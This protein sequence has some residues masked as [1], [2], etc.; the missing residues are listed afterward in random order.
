MLKRLAILVMLLAVANTFSPILGQTAGNDR[1]QGHSAQKG[2]GSSRQTAAEPV[3]APKPDTATGSKE[4]GNPSG[5]QGKR[6]PVT[7]TEF[8]VVSNKRDW[9]DYATLIVAW[10]L[11]VITVAGVIAAWRGL[12]EL[13]RQAEAAKDATAAAKDAIELSRDTAKRQLRAYVCVI[14]ADM[15]FTKADAP[16]IEIRIKNCG[17]TPAYEVK[18][19]AGLAAGKHPLNVPLDRPPDGFKMNQ[20]G[21]EMIHPIFHTPIP[22]FLLPI[23]GTPQATLYVYGE[24]TYRDA[25]KDERLTNFRMIYGGPEPPSLVVKGGVNTARLKADSE[26]NTAT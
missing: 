21:I 2:T 19:W 15:A 12:P 3:P 6:D 9:V 20:S 25:F 4:E 11:A 17:M 22:A 5:S 13:K 14:A 24:I 10:I 16:E 18:L 7:I 8:G 23:L 1:S 26:G